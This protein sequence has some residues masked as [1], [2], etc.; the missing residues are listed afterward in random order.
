MEKQRNAVLLKNDLID[1]KYKVLLFIKQGANAE[2]YRVKD[3]GGKIYFLKLFST[4]KTHRSSFDADGNLLE[5]EFLKKIKHPNIVGYKDSGEIIVNQVKYLYL[6]LHFISGETLAERIGRER[7]S[8]AYDVKQ[9]ISGILEGLKYL[10]Q[11]G[12]CIIHNEI[13]PQNIMLNLSGDV[14][15]PII[16]DFGHARSFYQSSKSFN[17][18]GLDPYYLAPEC[19]SNLYAPQSDLFSTGA[20]MY[21]LLFGMPPWYKEVPAFKASREKPEDIVAAEREKPPSFPNIKHQFI[22]F[23]DT[24][25]KIVNKALQTDIDQRFKTAAEFLEVLKGETPIHDI[26]IRETSQEN[27][28]AAPNL[29]RTER[30]TGKGFEAIAGMKDLKNLLQT[31]VIDALLHP[32][33]YAEYGVTIPNGM[34]LYGP[35]GC[36]KTYFAK[37]LA[38]EVGF[39]FLDLKPSDLASIYVHGSQEKIAKLF[40]EA[41]KNAPTI[42]FIDEL[43]ALVPNR[44]GN[45]NHSYA[46]EV[47]EFLAQM[48]N[49]AERGIFI[50]GATN[51]PEKIDTAILR[52]GRLDK[53]VYLPPP[54]FE[55]RKAMFELYLKSRPL[56]FG[57]DYDLL[58]NQTEHYVSADIELIVNDAARRALK[59]KARISMK[60]LE[61]VIK[62]N[63]PSVPLSEIQKY[64]ALRAKMEGEDD[65]QNPPERRHIG[66]N[67]N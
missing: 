24:I 23:E 27:T 22:G 1:N 32:D 66:F 51:R 43:D 10:H 6:V 12:D 49:C 19:L 34:L 37:R 26:L 62:G 41:K 46:S 31:E 56:D 25:L 7:I 35:P 28:P 52:A 67:K 64:Q 2:T 63:K 36:G 11:H 42:M 4:S 9:Y 53:K 59:E 38:E 13:T 17:R 54:D 15:V 57:I 3:G 33:Q 58:A 45:L 14:P 16:I 61:E 55:A 29:K 8:T 30:A 21:H 47:N 60:I 44:E 20:L 65:A 40:E 39:N 50:I 48:T 18:Q 5:I